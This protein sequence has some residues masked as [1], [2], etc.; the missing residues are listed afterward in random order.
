MQNIRIKELD[1][2]EL[3]KELPQIPKGTRG[4]VVFVYPGG[5]EVEVEFVDKEGNTISVE[6]VR[7]EF[8][9][10]VRRERKSKNSIKSKV[11]EVIESLSNDPQLRVKNPEQIEQYLVKHSRIIDV[12]L[13]A[14][15]SAKKHFPE[16]QLVFDLYRDPEIRDQYLV[17]YVRLRKYDKEDFLTRI[18]K[19]EAEFLDDL[20][21]KKGWI[22]LTTDFQEPEG[23][24]KINNS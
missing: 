18:N 19:A 14:I 12:V 24:Q 22:Q 5:D 9:K 21:G 4:T 15:N 20:V 16:A 10:K 13:K 3:T 8:L 23:G 6:N 2:V 11:N 17:L 7:V 1:F